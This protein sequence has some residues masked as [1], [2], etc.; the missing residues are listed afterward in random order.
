MRVGGGA[1]SKLHSYTTFLPPPPPLPGSAMPTRPLGMY[2][3]DDGDGNFPNGG[4]EAFRI[5]KGAWRNYGN[6]RKSCREKVG[7]K[8]ERPGK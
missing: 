8:G 2:D 1:I 5:F 6:F 4:D 7:G 3:D